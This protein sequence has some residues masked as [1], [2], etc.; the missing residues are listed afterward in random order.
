[1]LSASAGG[2]RVGPSAH[3]D[4]GSGRQS[5]RVYYNKLGMRAMLLPAWFEKKERLLPRAVQMVPYKKKWRY[6][7]VGTIP[8]TEALALQG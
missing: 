1:M 7:R 8:A 4:R 6:D 2:E 3:A 5:A